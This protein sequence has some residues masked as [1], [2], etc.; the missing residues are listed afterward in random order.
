MH[1]VIGIKQ[2][3]TQVY[4]ESGNRVV[5][6]ILDVANNVVVGKRTSEKDG[7]SATII[8]QGKVK[9][10]NKAEQGAYKTLGFVPE[11]ILELRDIELTAPEGNM[12]L[13]NV[14]LSKKDATVRA[15]AKGKGFQGVVKRHGF[16]GGKATH[17]QSDRMRH[18]GSIGNRTVPGRVY[19][20]RRMGGHMGTNVLTI[21]GLSIFKHM[22]EENLFLVAGSIPGAI[23]SKVL[24]TVQD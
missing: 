2:N 1:A 7:Y 21:K 3:M 5:V 13:E 24:I 18:P 16:K 8:G 11:M 22:V 17:G 19:K 6:T 14:D 12:V 20:G 9:K 4:D 10:P 15:A 23:G